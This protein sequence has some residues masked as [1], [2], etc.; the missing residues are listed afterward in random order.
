MKRVSH[1]FK[2]QAPERLA[3]RLDSNTCTS[4]PQERGERREEGN[5]NAEGCSRIMQEPPLLLIMVAGA[6][7]L[8][9]PL[10]LPFHHRF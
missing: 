3:A 8:Y 10:S 5:Q 9:N 4:I 7:H 6:N 1:A 2:H